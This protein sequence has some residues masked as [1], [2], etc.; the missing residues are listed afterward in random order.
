MVGGPRNLDGAECPQ[1][2]GDELGVEQAVMAG[3]EPRHQM[4]EGDL[5][6]IARAVE[7]ALAEKGASEADAVEAADQFAAFV[8]LNRMAVS[9]LVEPAVEAADASIDPGAGAPGHRL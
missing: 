6:G 3:L 1:M 4:D 7:H 5:G 2:F 9:A 8:H